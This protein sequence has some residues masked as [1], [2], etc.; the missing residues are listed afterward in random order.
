M[1]GS[2][3]LLHFFVEKQEKKKQ[4][5]ISNLKLNIFFTPLLQPLSGVATMG[6]A[7]RFLL[8]MEGLRD[9]G[10]NGN[11]DLSIKD[12]EKKERTER[13]KR[14]ERQRERQN[15]NRKAKTPHLEDNLVIIKDPKR[16]RVC[17]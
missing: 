1:T 8:D 4:G 2:V 16:T 3:I 14:R 11:C 13:E 7:D 9:L 10:K 12:F 5:K 6:L 17:L 15:P